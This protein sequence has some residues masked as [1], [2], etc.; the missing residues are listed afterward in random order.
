MHSIRN[1]CAVIDRGGLNRRDERKIRQTRAAF[2][3]GNRRQDTG[4]IGQALAF[5]SVRAA[6]DLAWD[7]AAHLRQL[8]DLPG[9]VAL[10]AQDRIAGALGRSLLFAL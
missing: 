9:Q 7:F 3:K 8:P 6:R 1:S 4:K 2:N 5:W 10:A